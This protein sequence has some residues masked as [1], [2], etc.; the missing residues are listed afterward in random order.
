MTGSTRRALLGRS[1]SVSVGLPLPGADLGFAEGL[2]SRLPLHV[3]HAAAIE[4]V[5]RDLRPELDGGSV[6]AR[7]HERVEGCPIQFFVLAE[8]GAVQEYFPARCAV[9]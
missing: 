4:R 9:L 5:Y 8:N 1:E 7:E 3:E 6:G 2:R